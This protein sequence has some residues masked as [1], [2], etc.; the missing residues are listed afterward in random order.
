MWL[1]RPRLVGFRRERGFFVRP[2]RSLKSGQPRPDAIG[3]GPAVMDAAVPV[4][5]IEGTG[6]RGIHGTMEMITANAP[7]RARVQCSWV[8][9]AKARI[10]EAIE[11]RFRKSGYLAL[12]D[13]SCL[14]Q[15]DEVHLL[16][17]LPSY[18]LKQIAQE[19][20]A[21]VEGVRRVINRIDVQRRS[22]STSFDRGEAPNSTSRA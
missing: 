15:E 18:F 2:A 11:E 3:S 19:I 13:V 12:R 21:G 9:P 17:R 1:R 7:E 4:K 14:A 20:A 8:R 16:G 6:R 10:Q 22:R 5:P